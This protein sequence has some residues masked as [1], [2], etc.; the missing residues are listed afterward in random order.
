[1]DELSQTVN[2][3]GRLLGE[4]LR[5]QEGEAAFTLVEEFRA[6]TKALRQAADGWPADF[7]K[8]GDALLD[9]TRGL[10][11]DETRLLVRAFTA[12]FHLVNVAEERHRLRVL[13]QREQA[14]SGPAGDPPPRKESVAE[15]VQ[16]AADEG[17]KS[18]Q[19]LALL[20]RALV[21]PVFTAHPTEAR[22][23]TVLEKLR[24]LAALAEPLDDPRLSP[25]ETQ[26][27]H[28]R[29]KEHIAALWRTEE[30]HRHPPAVF[31]E[32]RN[33]LY[34][35]EHAL[36]EAVPGLYRDVERAIRRAYGGDE[37]PDVPPLL[38][39]GSWIGGDRDGNPHVTAAV[40][41]QTLRLQEETALG[42]YEA[43]LARLQAHLSVVTETTGPALAESLER[44]ARDLPDVAGP[45]NR[46]FVAEPY[47]RK[48]AFMRAR[49][50]ATRRLVAARLPSPARAIGGDR[51]RESSRA[52]SDEALARGRLLWSD[53]VQAPWPGDT[54]VAYP[55]PQG[56]AA[57]LNLIADD[58]RDR[59]AR[60]LAD[61]ML[62][63]TVRRVEV[64]GFHLA[65]LDLREHSR[66]L[67]EA[68]DEVL[69]RAGVEED[70]TSLSEARRAEILA[71]E[72]ADPR[73]L[74]IPHAAYGPA[75]AELVRVFKTAARLQDELGPRACDAF[76]V[77]MTAGPSDLLAPLLFAKEAGLFQPGADPPRSAL[78]VVPLF[79]TIDDLRG[80]ADILRATFARPIYRRHLEA[81]GGRQ[82]VMLGYSDSD[83]DGGFTTANWE[84]YQAQRRLAAVCRESG[85]ELILFHGR[86][87]AIGRGGGPT[88][89]AILGQPTGTLDGRL[90]MT[91]Q[92]EAAFARYGHA[93]MAHRHLE[94]VLN[95]VLRASLGLVEHGQPRPEWERALDAVSA[96]AHAAY[97]RLVHD[98]ED[99]LMGYFRHATPIDHIAGLRIGSR[100]AKRKGGDRLAD[101]RAIPWVFSWNQSRHGLPG[102]YGLGT[103][104]E[105]FIR[106]EGDAGRAVL[107][108]MHDAWPFFRSLV[109]N[110]QMGLGK[111]DRAVARLYSRLAPGELRQRIWGA[112]DAEWERT[113]RALAEVTGARLLESAQV[114]RRSIRLRNPYVDPMSFVQVAL[115]ERLAH[116]PEDAPERDE[117]AR[118]VALSV[119]GIAAGLQNTG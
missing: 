33:G 21:E 8:E 58:L 5:E 31:D 96:A 23:R 113:E 22:R 99:A 18:A 44:D 86:G 92:G 61:G 88:N 7:G 67:T 60:R 40:T 43:D 20:Q 14:A 48:L 10:S 63:D 84:L 6:R 108:E 39:F 95:A 29:L 101:L 65:R 19:V 12:Y 103:G 115:L 3:L 73:P 38:V 66:V 80:C 34:Y 4:V 74:V 93:A 46:Q 77:S 114:L 109:D 98:E 55:D 104:V 53:E 97:R 110:A 82:Q 64:F 25:S 28:R 116:L 17:V 27:L 56:L 59:D 72:L 13:R 9:R 70:Y 89:R 69:A 119:N 90:R 52:E 62:R 35:F 30:V 106:K 42:L 83:K 45:A 78:Q 100:P 75:T 85:I 54:K 117:V 107:R 41:Q 94:Q 81:W 112:I 36:W 68:L 50:R 111:A 24:V 47:R 2:L 11:L 32:V 57:D 71:R 49:L 1:M 26:E 87:G 79:E 91:E 102:W 105:E 16:Q 15:A 37:R 51:R 76:I 118:I